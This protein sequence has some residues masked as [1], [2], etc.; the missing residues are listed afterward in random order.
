[1]PTNQPSRVHCHIDY[2][3][4][5]KLA[6]LLRGGYIAECYIPTR[7][8]MELRELVRHRAAL[9]RMRTK[10]KNKIHKIGHPLDPA[11][12]YRY[13][14]FVESPDMKNIYDGVVVLDDN[15]EAE[16]ERDSGFKLRKISP[17]RNEATTYI[18][19]FMIL[20]MVVWPLEDL[21]FYSVGHYLW[22]SP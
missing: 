16:I 3:D 13:H 9:V 1:M 7:G 21:T 6:D 5:V 2:L 18:Q 19:S 12:K 10:L 8:T 11:N 22:K 20:S 14:P 17:I 15:G 4:A